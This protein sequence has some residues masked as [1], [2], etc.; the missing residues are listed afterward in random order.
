LVINLWKGYA[1]A[2]DKDFRQWIKQKKGE[3]F[4]HTFVVNPN[5]LDLMELA[6]N[7][8]KDSVKTKDWM[9]LDEDQQT[10]LALQMEIQAVKASNGTPKKKGKRIDKNKKPEG[11]GDWA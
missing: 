9:K 2:K 1:R 8:Y 6:E 3:W 11:T 7:H 4:D 5:G 10:I